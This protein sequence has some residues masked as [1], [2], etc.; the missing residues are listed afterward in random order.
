MSFVVKNIDSW[1][2]FLNSSITEVCLGFF[3]EMYIQN[4]DLGFIK[5]PNYPDSQKP[6][7][8]NEHHPTFV[9]V[10]DQIC[11]DASWKL[12]KLKLFLFFIVRIFLMRPELDD[13]RLI[14]FICSDTY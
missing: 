9:H 4:Y 7:T 6:S 5:I 2:H 1:S 14:L 10:L 12:L 11:K 13:L 3:S 8:K